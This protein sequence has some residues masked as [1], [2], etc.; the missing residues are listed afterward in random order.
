MAASLSRIP[1]QTI[2]ADRT[3]FMALQSLSDYAPQNPI[4]SIAAIQQ[5]E[6]SLAQAA[7]TISRLLEALDQA[8]KQE[9][10]LAHLFHETMLGARQQV[11]SQYG[12]DSAVVEIIGLKRKSDRK[13]PAQRKAT[14]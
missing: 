8:R 13:R 9:N 6:I 1:P 2:A 12:A 10:E 4:Y 14:T 11:I 5:R 3:C 7:Q